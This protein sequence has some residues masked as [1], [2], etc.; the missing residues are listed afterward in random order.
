IDDINVFLTTLDQLFFTNIVSEL[1]GIIF[2]VLFLDQLINLR[3]R[4]TELKQLTEQL[5]SKYNPFAKDAARR[6]SLNE[7]G[8]D[9]DKKLNH[10]DLSDANLREAQLQYFNLRFSNL[11]CTNLKNADL[12]NS[13]L[14]GVSFEG[15][16]L[17]GCNLEGANL[18]NADLSNANLSNCFLINC[19]NLTDKQLSTAYSMRGAKFGIAR[20]KRYDGRYNLEGDIKLLRATDEY[21]EDDTSEVAAF[22]EVDEDI[23]LKGQHLF[24]KDTL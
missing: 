3:M 13:N 18:K 21:S 15:A 16:N 1:L 6:L 23:Y 7:W 19:I 20:H 4:K 5:G 24:Y 9:D 22:Y 12:S 17:Q 2:S 8:I 14:E 11:A 10:L